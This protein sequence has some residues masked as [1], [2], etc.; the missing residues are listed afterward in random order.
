M[1]PEQTAALNQIIQFIDSL[2]H[3]AKA[4]P[5][6]KGDKVIA[7]VVRVQSYNSLLANTISILKDMVN[8]Q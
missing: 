6:P 8:S 3:T 5:C 4:F 2:M 7:D 1:T